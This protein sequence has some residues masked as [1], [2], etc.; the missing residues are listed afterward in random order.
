M[1]VSDAVVLPHQAPCLKVWMTAG[2]FQRRHLDQVA[3]R[4]RP[5]KRRVPL[6]GP[7]DLNRSLNGLQLPVAVVDILP[8]LASL[9]ALREGLGFL[10][11]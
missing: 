3:K 5:K 10:L 2:D 9:A 8:P 6:L 1:N 4:S 7:D 11:G